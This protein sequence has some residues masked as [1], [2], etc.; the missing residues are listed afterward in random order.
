IQERDE[1][2]QDKEKRIYDLKKKNQELEKFKFVLDYKIKEL[3]RQIE[4]REQDIQG[5][6][7]Q[8]KA[9]P[10]PCLVFNSIE[11]DVEL[12]HYHKTNSNLELEIADLKLKLKAAEKEVEKEKARV[13]ACVSVIHRFKVDLNDCIQYIQE[14]KLLKANMKRLYQKYCKDTTHRE[15]TLE[16]DIQQ[17]YSR[18]RECLERTVASLRKKVSKEQGIHRS[19]N[20]R[21]MQENASLIREI[22]QL[23]KDV[24]GVRQKE[25]AANVVFKNLS[26]VQKD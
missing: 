26:A 20:V 5:M 6:T 19:D 13:K 15:E 24:R 10:I 25:R 18:Q 14:P 8:I 22:N 17:E 3:K 1:T 2:I 4:P 23:R 11:M 9:R 21:I 12:E 7:Q 16:V